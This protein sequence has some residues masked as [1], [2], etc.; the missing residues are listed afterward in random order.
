MSAGRRTFRRPSRSK[1]FIMSSL[2]LSRRRMLLA[3]SAIGAAALQSAPVSAAGKSADPDPDITA[4]THRMTDAAARGTSLPR[5]QRHLI[6]LGAV[7][8][9]GFEAAVRREAEAAL[10]AG[11]TPAE[12]KEA[13]YQCTPYAGLARIEAVLPT[14]NAVLREHG[15]TLP[16][17]SAATVTDADRFEKG[18]TVQIGIAGDRIRKMHETAGDDVRAVLVEDLSAW[19]FGDFYTRRV[20]D[21][22]DR[23]LI[24]F[25]VIAVLGGAE[26]QL[27]GHTNANISVGNV[28]QNLIDALRLAVPYLGFPRTLNALNVVR[29][30]LRNA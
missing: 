20:L 27:R 4:M 17:P 13:V 8:A 6:L 24:T 9:V 22:K 26:S 10:A 19:C 14:V 12:V 25:T 3:G 1:V 7:T 23:E 21:L 18:R 30:T 28:R 29:E 15:V 11:L 5:R 16:L 2:S